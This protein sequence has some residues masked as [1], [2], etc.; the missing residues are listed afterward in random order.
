VRLVGHHP[1]CPHGVPADLAE[2]EEGWIMPTAPST[3]HACAPGTQVALR[4][5]QGGEGN[6]A[7]PACPA[8]VRCTATPGCCVVIE[9]GRPH[10]TPCLV[11]AVRVSPGGKWHA[12]AP[13]PELGTA[14]GRPGQHLEAG[15]E[16]TCQA[17]L[18]RFPT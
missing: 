10:D 5:R 14:C 9:E 11:A 17:C 13:W 2:D 6:L 16:V 12:P 1:R 3:C 15:G 8:L 4:F 18:A 7:P